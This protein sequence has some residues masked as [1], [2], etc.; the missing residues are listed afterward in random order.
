M[1]EKL[2]SYKIL[3]QQYG[4]G[5]CLFRLSYDIKRKYGFLKRKYPAWEWGQKPLSYWLCKE[6]PSGVSEY[7]LFRENNTKS[8]FFPI[9]RPP[10]PPSEWAQDAICQSEELLK[11][12]FRYFANEQAYLGY[13]QPDWFK[14]PFTDQRDTAE[15]H[16]CD[17]EDFEPSRGDIKHIWEPSRFGWSYSLA[18]AYAVTGKEEY[19]EAFWRL[20]ELWMKSNPPQMGPNWQCGQEIGI[21]LMACVFALYAFWNS[22]AT[23]D[24]RIS[25]LMVLVA[26]FAER[27]EGNINYARAQMGNHAITE[28]AALWTTGLLFPEFKASRRWKKIAKWVLEDEV[29]RYNYPDG[30]Y[31]QHSMTYQ[32]LM[33]H[34]Y[35]WS[36][37]LG[38]LN[39]ERF[40]DLT[41]E[42]LKSSYQFLYQ[43]QDQQTGRTPNYG[44]NDGALILPLNGCDYLDY[45][46]IV[47]AWHFF[48]AHKQLYE[49][50]RWSE[51]LLWLFGRQALSS[52][53]SQIERVSKDF[54]A[55]GYFTLRGKESWAFVRCH[56]YHN[57]PNQAD[58]LHL[59]LWWQG[60]NVLRDSGSFIYYDPQNHWNDFFV[61]TPAHNTITV[62][63]TDQMIKGPRFR[64]YSLL[65]SR[66]IEH[67]KN[68]TVE[69]WQGEHYG[70][71]RLPSKAICRRMICRIDDICWL[72]V[73]DILG[74]GKEKATISWNLPDCE[75][76][77]TDN[78]LKLSTSQGAVYIGLYCC[79]ESGELAVVRAENGKRRLGW[80]SLYYGQKTPAPTFYMDACGNLPIRFISLISLGRSFS[81]QSNGL[82]FI[83]WSLKDAGRTEVKLSVPQPAR[84]ISAVVK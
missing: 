68:G 63:D 23:T 17:R 3:V 56:S 55:G 84:K 9:G 18:R 61:S 59:D 42:R 41:L 64:W 12:R 14:N 74:R 54:S 21:R 2:N 31:T 49:Q 78:V 66:F 10:Q 70:Y 71:K 60:I 72:V 8:F 38:Q 32:R 80:Q 33:F 75:Y 19:A 40:S 11:G 13:P 62:A 20:V 77:L 48:F 29:R 37:R 46:P 39:G 26:A 76:N 79:L 24:E 25:S 36:L 51:D 15:K 65:Q 35:L 69:S 6:V 22:S 43:L 7:R 5:R 47:G 27:I 45:R 67:T 28:A 4:L 57:R 58:M 53:V 16:W 50:G 73:D 81:A 34:D 44:P 82:D 83:N 52:P 30:A 1:F